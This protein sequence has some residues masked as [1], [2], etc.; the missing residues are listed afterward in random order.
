M[1]LSPRDRP[2]TRNWPCGCWTAHCVLTDSG[3]VQE[4]C[5]IFKVP[6]VT[7]RDV[8]ERPETLE[9]GSNLLTGSDPE[10]ILAAVGHAVSL[11][12][13]WATPAEYTERSVSSTVCKILLGYQHSPWRSG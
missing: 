5:C 4:E 7:M 10:A 9:C 1:R 13:D 3:T 12:L 8:T 6:N 11:A 2:P